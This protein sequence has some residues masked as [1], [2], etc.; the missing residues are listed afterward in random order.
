MSVCCMWLTHTIIAHHSPDTYFSLTS[1]PH[2]TPSP[3]KSP[4]ASNMGQT[5]Q[6][7][8]HQEG[9]HA[10]VF[11]HVWCSDG[12]EN[13][14]DYNKDRGTRS[15][16][17]TYCMGRFGSAPE[18]DGDIG[19]IFPIYVAH[20]S[21]DLRALRVKMMEELKVLSIGGLLV[22]HAGLE[23]VVRARVVMNGEVQEPVR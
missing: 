4:Y 5:H 6:S 3:G 10:V 21:F 19:L 17:Y 7:S 11:R 2:V 1:L 16:E 13:S 22:Y 9:T 18:H 8:M 23:R 14:S 15:F 20:K 12:A